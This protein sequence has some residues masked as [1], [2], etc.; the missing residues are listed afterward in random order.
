MMSWM[1]KA[2]IDPGPVERM[3]RRS[4]K[5]RQ[6]M[7]F[8][9]DHAFEDAATALGTS[10]RRV[11]GFVRG[12]VFKVAGEEHRRILHRW[13][14]DIDQQAAELTAMAIKMKKDA[15]LEWSAENQYSLPL[16][17]PSSGRPVSKSASGV[18]GR[19]S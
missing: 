9:V 5:L 17:E 12:E 19:H 16:D 15:D 13:R 6:W 3:V 2:V 4:V 14:A 1:E 18:G 10:P 11:R 8:K 7:G